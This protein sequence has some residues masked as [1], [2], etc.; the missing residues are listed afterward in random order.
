MSEPVLSPDEG[1]SHTNTIF[2]KIISVLIF[3]SLSVILNIHIH[4][5]QALFPKKEY[6]PFHFPAYCYLSIKSIVADFYWFGLV[7]QEELSPEYAFHAADFITDLDPHFTLV[8]RFVAIYLTTR[9]DRQDLAVQLLEKSLLSPINSNDWRIH[10]YLAYQYQYFF[11]DRIQAQ[12]YYA[13]AAQHSS[14][15]KPP[16]YLKRLAARLKLANAR[17]KKVNSVEIAHRI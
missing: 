11:N 8:Y 14:V 4:E 1:S 17:K 9:T 16:D 13:Q 15:T 7:A 3:Y 10:F 6:L 12:Y 2:L 5:H